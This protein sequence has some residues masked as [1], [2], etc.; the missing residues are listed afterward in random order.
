MRTITTLEELKAL[1]DETVIIERPDRNTCA[2]QKHDGEWYATSD[3]A[4]PYRDEE[5][6]LPALIIYVPEESPN[7]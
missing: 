4:A 3:A 7:A 2:T 6:D 5:I 1:P